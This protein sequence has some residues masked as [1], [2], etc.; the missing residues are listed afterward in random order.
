MKR[1]P[2]LVR[3]L[4]SFVEEKGSRMFKGAVIIDGYERDAVVHHLYLLADAGLIELGSNTLGDKGPL[5]LT[6]KGCDYVD[7][8]RAAKA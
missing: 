2:I 3:K 1:D 8:Q 5:V 6:W 7:Q 4:L